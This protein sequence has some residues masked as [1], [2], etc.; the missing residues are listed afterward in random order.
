MTSFS[1]LETILQSGYEARSRRRRSSSPNSLE[2][3]EVEQEITPDERPTFTR[4]MSPDFDQTRGY[5]TSSPNP[6]RGDPWSFRHQSVSS[7][8]GDDCDQPLTRRLSRRATTVLSKFTQRRRTDPIGGLSAISSQTP[9]TSSEQRTQRPPMGKERRRSSLQKLKDFIA[10]KRKDSAISDASTSKCPRHGDDGCA[11]GP[12]E[13]LFQMRR[14]GSTPANPTLLYNLEVLPLDSIT[15]RLFERTYDFADPPTRVEDPI[16]EVHQSSSNFQGPLNSNPVNA[17]FAFEPK[18][19]T[20]DR[21]TSS[22]REEVSSIDGTHQNLKRKRSQQS[23]ATA[24]PELSHLANAQQDDQPH[25]SIKRRSFA[26]GLR[27]SLEPGSGMFTEPWVYH[28]SP[29]PPANPPTSIEDIGILPPVSMESASSI[30]VAA[31]T[32]RSANSST[33][34]LHTPSLRSRSPSRAALDNRSTSV[35][36]NPVASPNT[37]PGSSFS[38]PSPFM[39]MPSAYPVQR[40]APSLLQTTPVVSSCMAADCSSCTVSRYVEEDRISLSAT[41]ADTASLREALPLQRCHDIVD[42]TRGAASAAVLTDKGDG[43]PVSGV[44]DFAALRGLEGMNGYDFA[45]KVLKYERCGDDSEEY[46]ARGRS[47]VRR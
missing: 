26:S 32:N 38:L 11:T 47:R 19:D 8:S 22:S 24:A 1:Q 44:I 42:G 41:E 27:I 6:R 37:S 43:M 3:E 35:Q 4:R 40:S 25:D 23:G 31:F 7:E 45:R 46:E 21:A 28:V 30:A 34:A 9:D 39:P 14:T 2:E 36:I 18:A 5:G 16:E 17:D 10:R 29:T 13:S 33:I 15:S 20:E 12:F